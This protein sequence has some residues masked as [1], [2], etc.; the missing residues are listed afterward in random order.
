MILN[1]M[2]R[3]EIQLK[4]GQLC[5]P[6]SDVSSCIGVVEHDLQRYDVTVEIL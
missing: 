6:L 2:T 4:R 1:H 5:H 3:Q